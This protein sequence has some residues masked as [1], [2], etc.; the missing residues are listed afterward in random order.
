[1]SYPM[2]ATH[3]AP[4]TA[5]IRDFLVAAWV[6]GPAWTIDVGGHEYPGPA[7]DMKAHTTQGAVKD[8]LKTWAKDH[9]ELFV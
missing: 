3:D 4:I 6:S 7:V 5:T 1:M 2:D 9:A 8:M